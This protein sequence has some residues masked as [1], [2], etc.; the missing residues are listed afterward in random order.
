MKRSALKRVTALHKPIAKR[1]RQSRSTGKPT[2]AQSA[3]IDAIKRLGCVAC[4]IN[5]VLWIKTCGFAGA[6]AH[7]LLS[8]GRRRGHGFTIGL[9]PWHHRAIPPMDGMGEAV[10]IDT[11][12][13]SVAT[14]SKQFAATYGTDDELLEFQNAL[15]D[16]VRYG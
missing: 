3:R 2:K 12:G 7:H 4:M 11:Y 16:K 8:G 15:L 6:D 13:P 14:G 5:R 9:C 10:A 1:M